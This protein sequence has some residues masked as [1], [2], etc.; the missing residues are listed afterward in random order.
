MVH[1]LLVGADSWIN[2]RYA[3]TQTPRPPF[4][5]EKTCVRNFSTL[6]WHY[7]A[8]SERRE[9]SPNLI[10]W[11]FFC[12]FSPRPAMERDAFCENSERLERIFAK[13]AIFTLAVREFVFVSCEPVL[14]DINSKGLLCRMAGSSLEIFHFSVGGAS[15][16]GR[17]EA[18][19]FM[20][21]PTQI[22][23]GP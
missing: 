12:S 5:D 6:S 10:K 13:Y 7:A 2:S 15:G 11:K 17:C 16:G 1:P 23:T 19:F 21:S 18:E 8:A 3:H 20:H 4:P 14:V 22:N 9:K